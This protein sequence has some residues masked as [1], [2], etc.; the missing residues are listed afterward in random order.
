MPH[1]LS[2]P[3]VGGMLFLCFAWQARQ[4]GFATLQSLFASLRYSVLLLRSMVI[5]EEGKEHRGDQ[6]ELQSSSEESRN[7]IARFESI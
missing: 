5:I 4:D 6:E 7:R 3:L 1:P 2:S